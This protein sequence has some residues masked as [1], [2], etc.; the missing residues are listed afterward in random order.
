MCSS[1]KSKNNRKGGLN[2]R[3]TGT[4]QSSVPLFVAIGLCDIEAVKRLLENGCDANER[5]EDGLTPLMAACRYPRDPYTPADR[6]D[7]VQLL[8]DYGAVP[9]D[10]ASRGDL[11]T[12]PVDLGNPLI[13][14]AWKGD[15]EIVRRLLENGAST[16]VLHSKWGTPLVIAVAL[17]HLKCVEHLLNA[18]A[19]T[20]AC[21]P[22]E[23]AL[24]KASQDG[25]LEIVNRLIDAGADV[26]AFGDG[27][28]YLKN[29]LAE[30]SVNGHVD[31]VKAL[32]AAGADL[33]AH[34]FRDSYYEP[35]RETTALT[36]ALRAGKTDAARILIEAGADPNLGDP[37]IEAVSLEDLD[38]VRL[39][40]DR[41]ACLDRIYSLEEMQGPFNLI[42]YAVTFGSEEVV[43]FLIDA[44]NRSHKS[45][46]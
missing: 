35:D 7:L 29:A 19:N 45:K 2:E 33:D 34:T 43:E 32:I 39:L 11:I 15:H 22:K 42:E 36:E 12:D 23:N 20:E 28:S 40:V 6:M 37:I 38:F 21:A 46:L 3:G 31:V 41:G 17:G 10:V 14:A 30:A 1:T 13:G 9:Y 18:G 27:D 44:K 25:R 4:V 8:L 24:V 5:N 16:E 26:N